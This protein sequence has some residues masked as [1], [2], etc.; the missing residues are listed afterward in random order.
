MFGYATAPWGE[1]PPSPEFL[2]QYLISVAVASV[3]AAF[4]FKM[5]RQPKDFLTASGVA[6]AKV[7]RTAAEIE[8]KTF[9]VAGL[10]VPIIHQ[11]MLS[12]GFD[13]LVCVQIC[14][15]ITAVG[16][17]MDMVR[18][19]FPSG[20]V[21]RHWPLAKLLRAHEKSQLT[22]GCFFSLGCTL[23]IAFRCK[24][25]YGPHDTHRT[26]TRTTHTAETRR[27]AHEGKD[28]H[29][30]AERPSGVRAPAAATQQRL[31]MRADRRCQ[32]CGT[33]T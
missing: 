14:A 21:A 31:E 33:D 1:R 17:A 28:R 3:L 10:L 7:Q 32:L 12:A 22:G 25:K 9:H 30:Y 29:S 6:L 11:A 2:F 24:R 16:W 26:H 15:G 27:G 20:V 8:R 18:V 19:R 4:A 23:T 5:L 13:N